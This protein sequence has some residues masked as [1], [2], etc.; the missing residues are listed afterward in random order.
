VNAFRFK[1]RTRGHVSVSVGV[2]MDYPFGPVKK[3]Y[4]LFLFSSFPLIRRQVN[5][6]KKRASY[7][8][9]VRAGPW[10]LGQMGF[11]L[12]DSCL[13]REMKKCRVF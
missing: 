7:S 6:Q 8:P 11:A 5:E 4:T 13:A 9:A 2:V 10:A 12:A 1:P 3:F